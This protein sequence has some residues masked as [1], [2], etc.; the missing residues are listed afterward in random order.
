MRYEKLLP[1]CM[2]H[3]CHDIW[4]IIAMRYETLLPW[5]MRKLLPWGMIYYC[6]DISD[7]IASRYQYQYDRFWGENLGNV[8]FYV[9]VCFIIYYLM[10]RIFGVCLGP[11]Q[12]EIQYNT[13]QVWDREIQDWYLFREYVIR[14]EVGRI[15]AIIWDRKRRRICCLSTNEQ[16]ILFK[17]MVNRPAKLHRRSRQHSILFCINSLVV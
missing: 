2:R 4:D 16:D 15:A 5:D 3:Y 10:L 6:H 17:M 9:L 8:F 14:F 1:W 11:A 13:I 12:H 7:I